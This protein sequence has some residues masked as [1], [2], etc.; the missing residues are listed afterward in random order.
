MVVIFGCVPWHSNDISTES[1][2]SVP[3]NSTNWVLFIEMNLMD[4]KQQIN[5]AINCQLKNKN[6]NLEC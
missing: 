1:D 6:K 5:I 2:I 3:S 4:E